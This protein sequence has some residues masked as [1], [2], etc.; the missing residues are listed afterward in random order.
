MLHQ[1]LH[2]FY[3]AHK[4]YGIGI[5]ANLRCQLLKDTVPIQ[6]ADVDWRNPFVDG[7]ALN[8]VCL[9]NLAVD[10]DVGFEG[11]FAVY[12]CDGIVGADELCRGV[13]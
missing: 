6:S 7:T 4:I 1:R 13:L 3:I 9:K 10:G 5:G 8:S 2:K 11:I 12:N